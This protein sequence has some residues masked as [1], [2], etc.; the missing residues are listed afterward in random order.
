[1]TLS[2][3]SANI[4][5]RAPDTHTH[6]HFC[7]FTF[8]PDYQSGSRSVLQEFFLQ[9]QS[10]IYMGPVGDYPIIRLPTAAARP[11]SA[12]SKCWP[13]PAATRGVRT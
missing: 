8:T 5:G 9:A 6:T 11:E 10:S 4:P 1:M 3:R 12:T 2:P 7:T 13:Y